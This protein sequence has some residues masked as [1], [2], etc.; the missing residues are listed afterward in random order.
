MFK[1]SFGLS[2]D[3]DYCKPIIIKGAF[4]NNYIQYESKGDK[5]KNLSI[6]IYLNMIRSYLS[7]IIKNHKTQGKWRVHSGN[8]IIQCK[9]QSEWKIQLTMAIN[10]IS[11]KDSGE[12][13]TMH[14]KSSN[15]EIMMGSETDE[16]IEELLKSFLQ[17]CQEGLEESMRVIEFIFDSVDLF[18]YN[19]NKTSLSRG[20][21][22]IDSPKWLKTKKAT[23]NPKNNDD[24][25]FQYALAVALNYQNIKTS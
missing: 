16:I 8:K 17:K 21:S 18:Y 2:I 13:R 22:Y 14:A 7:D 3:E 4:N 10:F 23:I 24:K 25:C 9:T 20:G 5:R 12:T 19:F 15:V 1:D 11:S 6:K